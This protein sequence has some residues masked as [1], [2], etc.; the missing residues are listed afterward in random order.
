[1]RARISERLAGWGWQLSTLSCR[2]PNKSLRRWGLRAVADL[3]LIV[4]A[5]LDIERF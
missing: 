1:M 4:A 2:Y 3:C 5:L